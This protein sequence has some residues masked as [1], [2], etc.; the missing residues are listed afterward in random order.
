[1]I[2]SFYFTA[3]LSNRPINLD[4]GIAVCCQLVKPIVTNE[5]FSHVV[6]FYDQTNDLV[7]AQTMILAA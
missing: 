1:M 6:Y 5:T 7:K 2:N 4:W 3:L